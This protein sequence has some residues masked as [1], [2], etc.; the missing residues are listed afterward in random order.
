M[1]SVLGLRF[2]E[3]AAVEEAFERIRAAGDIRGPHPRFRKLA[4]RRGPSGVRMLSGWNCTPSM[5]CCAVA[6]AHDLARPACG[7]HFE[8]RGQR[9]GDGDQRVIAAD[10][11]GL[12]QAREQ[13]CAVV[14]D[15]R[16][17]AVHRAARRARPRRRRLRRSPGGRGRRRAAARGPRRRAIMSRATCRPRPACR[18]RA[19]CTGAS[20]RARSASSTRDRRRCGARARRAPSTANACTR[21]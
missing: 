20:A 1:S 6:H 15:R 13:P 9:L 19:K 12:R 2:G 17:L 18:G 21:L 16:G 10:L 14:L 8:R 3:V 5:G 4:S 7:G 11:A